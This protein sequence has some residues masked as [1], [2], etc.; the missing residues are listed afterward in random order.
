MISLIIIFGANLHPK[1]G[2]SINLVI[3]RYLAQQ[4]LFLFFNK[5]IQPIKKGQGNYDIFIFYFYILSLLFF[6]VHGICL[7]LC[8]SPIDKF[9][10]IQFILSER[11]FI[12]FLSKYKILELFR[13]DSS[14]CYC[15]RYF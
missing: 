9:K 5:I 6:R 7:V 11:D 15:F 1:N 12:F 4:L 14:S 8:R 3:A 10:V 13:A 2:K